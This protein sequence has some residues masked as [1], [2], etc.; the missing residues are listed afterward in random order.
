MA[1][2][3]WV[4]GRGVSPVLNPI[5]LRLLGGSQQERG[6]RVHFSR[7]GRIPTPKYNCFS[8][9]LFEMARIP[10]GEFGAQDDEENRRRR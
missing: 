8:Q 10:L 3:S 1:C 7:K 4:G 9:V 6:A 5:V 2:F